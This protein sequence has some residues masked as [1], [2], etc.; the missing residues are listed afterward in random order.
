MSMHVLIFQFLF[1]LLFALPQ[2]AGE[3][4]FRDDSR[5]FVDG[6]SYSRRVLYHK[7]AF[8]STTMR[9]AALLLVYS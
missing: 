8:D 7:S 2:T 5:D 4:F 3:T 9:C 6:P 1:K